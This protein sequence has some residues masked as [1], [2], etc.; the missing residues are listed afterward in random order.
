[1]SDKSTENNQNSENEK[2]ERLEKRLDLIGE[3]VSAIV[4]IYLAV[5]WLMFPASASKINLFWRND[6][7]AYSVIDK[8]A[9]TAKAFLYPFYLSPNKEK[10][11]KQLNADLE[12]YT[13][14]EIVLNDFRYYFDLNERHFIFDNNFL[15]SDYEYYLKSF[16]QKCKSLPE[17]NLSITEYNTMANFCNKEIEGFDLYRAGN[18][19]RF[20][21]RFFRGNLFA[22][23]KKEIS[24]YALLPMKAEPAPEESPAEPEVALPADSTGTVTE[25]DSTESR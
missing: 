20:K 8:L 6:H 9:I 1:M 3:I 11:E 19:R 15:F 22:P 13:K 5:G 25:Q 24:L 16:V 23:I 17:Q 2:K 14:N 21:D 4:V 12:E 10:V 7:H 18:S